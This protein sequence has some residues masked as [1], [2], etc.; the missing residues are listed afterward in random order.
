MNEMEDHSTDKIYKLNKNA[1]S[2]FGDD[3]TKFLSHTD[4]WE[5]S[6]TYRTQKAI[7]GCPKWLV[8]SPSG[9]TARRDGEK[10]DEFPLL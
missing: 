1:R 5:R 4:R 8:Y 2:K 10:G 7:D 9:D 6:V 3:G